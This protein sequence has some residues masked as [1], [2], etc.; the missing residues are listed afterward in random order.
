MSSFQRNGNPGGTQL[1]P[2]Q[3]GIAMEHGTL[4]SAELSGFI[5]PTSADRNVP[6][7]QRLTGRRGQ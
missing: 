7:K 1:L 2:Q 3:G 6:S 5:T 4:D